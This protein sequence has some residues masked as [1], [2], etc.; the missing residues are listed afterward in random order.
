MIQ[1]KNHFMREITSEDVN[2][3]IYPKAA[4][5]YEMLVE[6]CAPLYACSCCGDNSPEYFKI[7]EEG[8]SYIY[9]H[10]KTLISD[11]KKIKIN[12]CQGTI[13]RHDHNFLRQFANFYFSI[14]MQE[15]ELSEQLFR[16]LVTAFFNKQDYASIRLFI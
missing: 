1:L 12:D 7:A 11:F 6:Y 16:L 3:I 5:Y 15:N 4:S 9:A 13:I 2:K 14:T 10:I 8:A